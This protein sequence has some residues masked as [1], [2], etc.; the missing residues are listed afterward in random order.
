MAKVTVPGLKN[1]QGMKSFELLADGDYLLECSKCEIKAP[2]S[3][4]EGRTADVWNFAFNVLEGPPQKDGKL[5]KNRKHMEWVT[6]LKDV[7][8]SYKPSWDDPE[9]GESQFAVDQLKSMATAMGIAI[10]GDGIDPAS[11][12]GQRCRVHLSQVVD[13]KDASKM[14]QR[15]G[16]WKAE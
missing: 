13:S 16:N 8:P 9:S 2:K 4:P 7:H 14:R 5:A 11:F 12:I 15:S 10:R 3:D 6:I 1:S